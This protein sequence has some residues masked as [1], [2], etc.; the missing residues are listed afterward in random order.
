M[1]RKLFSVTIKD[2]KV[3]TF[4]VGGNGGGGKDTSNTGVRVAHTASGATGKATESRSQLSNKRV[5]F[6]RMAETKE[7][8]QWVKVEAARLAG[9]P[10]PE[11]LV[12]KAMQ[13]ENLKV[14]YRTSKGWEN[15]PI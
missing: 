2:C 8:R 15:E 9:H 3:D 1:R 13:P 14:E 5:A 7:F 12:E 11:E 6:R 4:T 10:S